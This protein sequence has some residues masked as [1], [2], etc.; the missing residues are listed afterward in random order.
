MQVVFFIID[1]GTNRWCVCVNIRQEISFSSSQM[2]TCMRAQVGIFEVKRNLGLHWRIQF[3]VFCKHL[4]IQFYVH[5]V[6]YTYS[7]F[8][9]QLSFICLFREFKWMKF[10]KNMFGWCF[11]FFGFFHFISP[12]TPSFNS[13]FIIIAYVIDL[14]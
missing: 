11:F 2:S 4:I 14:F 12:P 7:S 1:G 5:I 13:L 3:L 8:C 6:L 9:N 10:I